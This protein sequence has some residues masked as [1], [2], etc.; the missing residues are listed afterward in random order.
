MNASFKLGGCLKD[1][2]KVRFMADVNFMKYQTIRIWW[3]LADLFHSF[4]GNGIGID[5]I[6]NDH[7][8][9]VLFQETHNR[10][11]PDVAAAPCD[12]DVFRIAVA[13][14]F[15]FF[16]HHFMIVPAVVPGTGTHMTQIT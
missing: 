9:V 4:Q 11:R 14:A 16:S 1:F 2:T 10:M 12:K 3:Q 7:D 6:V 15:E 8:R 5:K 13:H